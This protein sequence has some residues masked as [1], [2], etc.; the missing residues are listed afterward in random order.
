METRRDEAVL[1]IGVRGGPTAT[2]KVD[3]KDDQPRPWDLESTFATVG[4]GPDRLDAVAK[5]T[6]RAKYTHDV[7]L[8]NMVFGKFVRSPHAA[9]TV[10][11]VD[12]SAALSTPGVVFAKAWGLKNVKYPWQAVAVVAAET[13][14]ALEAGLRAVRVDYEVLPHAAR[15]EQAMAEGAPIVHGNAKS[16][17]SG[18][19]LDDAAVARVA[20]AHKAAAKV[21]EGTAKTQ[22]QTHSCLETKGVVVQPL[23]DGKWKIF[24]STQGTF[25]V[26]SEFARRMNVKEADVQVIT[27]YMGGG[28]GSK[29]GLGEFGYAAGEI[30]RE[31]KRPVKF[32]L[33]RKEEHMTGG[34]RPNSEQE[35]KLGVAADGKLSGYRVVKRGSGGVVGGAGAANPLIYDVGPD[36]AAAFEVA[37]NAGAAA[38]FRAPGHPQGSF[39]MEAILDEAA[40]AVGIDPLEIR[41][42]NDTNPVRLFQYDAGAKIFGWSK[43][44]Q[45]GADSGPIKR[46]MGLASAVWFQFGGRG[47]SC[48]CRIRKDGS[49]EIRNGAQDIG[50]GTKTIMA[51]IVAEELGL[52]LARVTPF[53]GD[54]SDPIGPGSGGSTTAPTIMPAARKAA[55]QAG[56]ELRELVAKKLGGAPGNYVFAG[57]SVSD[58][59]APERSMSFEVA[60]SLIESDAIEALA[61]RDPNFERFHRQTAG[62]HFAEVE[63]DVETGKVK[64]TRYLAMQDSGT[65]VNKKTAESQ[66]NGAIVQGVSYALFEERHLDRHRGQQINADMEAYK[67]AGPVEMPSV[68]VVLTDCVMGA[69]NVGLAG[70]GE[71][72][73][74]PPAAAIGNAVKN[75]LGV[76]V[77]E[78][79]I[80][81]DRVLAA[82]SRGGRDG[83]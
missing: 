80:T 47:A 78:L 64:V 11:S 17:V 39:A 66:V 71:G 14:E 10:L 7:A 54:T 83:R 29:F 27:H 69:N 20:S 6:G 31:T 53:L 52:P 1:K 40:A 13:R 50:T 28:F 45:D 19:D 21:V 51:M 67:I 74:V 16:N 46:G 57:G 42:K 41:K 68:Q 30:A 59:T 72:P 70:L 61:Q 12:V 37:T 24:A 35:M 38:A 75:A 5:V 36:A 22:V 44:R 58:A 2:I 3:V 8:P 73:A 76:R 32:L 4:T 60:C 81:P 25:S 26:R 77:W 18:D 82:L 43:R 62:V 79:P 56:R 49:V 15:F 65:I 63:V 55:F 48:L 33:D 23:D 9:A 34:N